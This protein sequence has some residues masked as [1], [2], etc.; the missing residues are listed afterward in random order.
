M[1]TH[2]RISFGRDDAAHLYELALE[3]FCI[4]KKEGICPMCANLKQ[5]LEKCI[6]KKEAAHM[7]RQVKKHG[8]CKNR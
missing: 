1:S 3:H 5:R 7:L 2:T 6:S 4:S 8:Y